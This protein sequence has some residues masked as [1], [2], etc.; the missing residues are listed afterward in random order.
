MEFLYSSLS[1]R[2]DID[3][4]GLG[5][6]DLERDVDGPGKSSEPLEFAALTAAGRFFFVFLILP[7][8]SGGISVT[9]PNKTISNKPNI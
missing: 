5:V 2:T 1:S 3:V 6:L 8:F 7:A 9:C 4:C